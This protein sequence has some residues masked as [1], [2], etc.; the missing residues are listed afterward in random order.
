MLQV[1]EVFSGVLLYMGCI[2]TCRGTGYGFLRFSFR[3]HSP[4][5]GLRFKNLSSTPL[6]KIRRSTPRAKFLARFGATVNIIETLT[7]ITTRGCPFIRKKCKI[8]QIHVPFFSLSFT[9]IHFI[10]QH[11]ITVEPPYQHYQERLNHQTIHNLT[12][13]TETVYGKSGSRREITFSLHS[14]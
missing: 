10:L 3:F 2:D 5:I 9:R 6:F 12:N 11:W 14:K 8:S 4:L 1:L 13:Q 7:L